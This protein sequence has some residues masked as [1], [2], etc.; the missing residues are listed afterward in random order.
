M[1]LDNFLREM[2]ERQ[3]REYSQLLLF[4]TDDTA[5][6]SDPKKQYFVR[7]FYHTR[8]HFDR[9]L[10]T[11]LVYA[12]T[13]KDKRRILDYMAEE[14]GLEG[15]KNRP[16]HERLFAVFAESLGVDLTPEITEGEDYLPFARDF[17]NGLIQWFRKNDWESGEVGFAAYER[18]DNV[19]YE[20][21]YKLA[22]SVRVPE[23]AMVFFRVHKEAR[24]F[25]K[26]S[27]NLPQVWRRNEDKVRNA[28]DFIYNH[29]LKM[30]KGL[31]DAVGKYN[32]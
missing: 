27:G 25:E 23:R 14:A 22:Q 19:D 18:L 24:H 11:R 28:F 16:S 20:F 17:N 21:M 10:W 15:R 29:Q 13:A 26:T 4:D 12:P 9:L 32:G 1:S 8:G 6:W 2:D 7:V 31:S 30:W 3:S 5:Q